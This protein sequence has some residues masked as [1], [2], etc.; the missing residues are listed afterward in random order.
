[1]IKLEVKTSFLWNFKSLTK[2]FLVKGCETYVL[3][4]TLAVFGKNPF[5]Y[6]EAKM[7]DAKKQTNRILF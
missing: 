4:K 7:T 6:K 3:M 2:I 1:M 5:N